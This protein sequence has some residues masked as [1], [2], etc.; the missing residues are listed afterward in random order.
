MAKADPLLMMAGVLLPLLLFFGF[1][2]FIIW[3]SQRAATRRRQQTLEAVALAL[4]VAP[5]A[6]SAAPALEH[7]SG[8]QSIRITPTRRG[9]YEY[10]QIQLRSG[11]AL[12]FLVLRK[13]TA[14]D[15]LGR[16][17]G[18]NHLAV[19]LA[20][21]ISAPILP[22]LLLWTINVAADRAPVRTTAGQV[23]DLRS[24]RGGSPSYRVSVA[25]DQSPSL[26]TPRVLSLRQSYSTYKQLRRGEP[27]TVDIHSGAFGWA[28]AD[29]VR[30]LPTP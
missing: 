23:T 25:L 11:H 8:E 22:G 6:G 21:L 1:L 4:G 3:A 10:L 18:L 24:T 2:G 27:V 14:L 26:P 15:R 17:L 20:S 28:Y 5:P 13:E 12:P 16:A 19:L 9:K 30:P 7:R 29:A